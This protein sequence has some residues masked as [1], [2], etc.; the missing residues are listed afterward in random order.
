MTF[1]WLFVWIWQD[2]LTFN[3]TTL[4]SIISFRYAQQHYVSDCTRWTMKSIMNRGL[5]FK[6]LLWPSYVMHLSH[7]GRIEECSP[8]LLWLLA[9]QQKLPWG[10]KGDTIIHLETSELIP[11]TQNLNWI[12]NKWFKC[13]QLDYHSVEYITLPRPYWFIFIC[14]KVHTLKDNSPLNMPDF[15]H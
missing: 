13:S 8:S 3:R 9:G 5:C 12:E 10:I 15:C 4:L 11:K 14:N 1:D 7:Q 2:V 6:R